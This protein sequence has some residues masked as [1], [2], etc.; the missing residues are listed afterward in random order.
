MNK[1][2]IPLIILI[3]L[4]F[5]FAN[6]ED[7]KPNEQ[8]LAP[9]KIDNNKREQVAKPERKIIDPKILPKAKEVISETKHLKT[10]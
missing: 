3:A 6:R 2:F 5:Y 7:A 9:V 1:L 10:K 4:G 8:E